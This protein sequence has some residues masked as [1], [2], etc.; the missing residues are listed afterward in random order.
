MKCVWNE[1]GYVYNLH[2]YTAHRRYQ[3]LYFPT[4][5]LN[6]INCKLLKTH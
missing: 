4:N 5:A 1:T 3:K 6:Y 2:G